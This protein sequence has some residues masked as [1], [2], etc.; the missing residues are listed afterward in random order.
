MKRVTEID[1]M[2]RRVARQFTHLVEWADYQAGAGS[3]PSGRPAR[4]T[5]YSSRP[6][7]DDAAV[8]DFD[9]LDAA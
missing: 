1:Q 9:L 4:L 3:E 8:D 5:F 7:S 2:V 6:G